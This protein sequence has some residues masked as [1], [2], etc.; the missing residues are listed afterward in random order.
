MAHPD[1]KCPRCG[2]AVNMNDC[3]IYCNHV[4]YYGDDDAVPRD[5]E[6]CNTA[7]YIKENV[8]RWWTVVKTTEEAEDA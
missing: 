2:T 6:T 8:H 5:C 4:T 1:V 3:E 7:F